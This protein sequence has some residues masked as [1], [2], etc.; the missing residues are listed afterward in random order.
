LLWRAELDR[1]VIPVRASPAPP[2]HPDALDLGR[3]RAF[4]T[5]AR[6]DTGREY[7]ALSDGWRRIRL[8]VVEGTLVDS[9][10]VM[11]RYDLSGFRHLDQRLRTIRR[12]AALRRAGQLEQDLYP[13]PSGL[14]RRLEALRV[15]DALRDGASYREIAV[16][17][18]GEERVHSDWRTRSDFLLS[19]I[20]RRA[21][22]ARAMLAGGYKA[23]LGR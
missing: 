1:S 15:A 17:L 20:R 8:D 18:F 4:A 11:F 13:A 10:W 6:G 12:L 16:A 9:P 23:L 2:D 14:P 7:L 19:R 22:E 21:A 3:L 5:L